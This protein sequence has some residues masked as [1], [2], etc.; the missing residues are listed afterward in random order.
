MN[1]YFLLQTC[2]YFKI[3][4][5]FNISTKLISVFGPSSFGRFLTVLMFGP[6]NRILSICLSNFNK[7]FLLKKTLPENN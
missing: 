7:T 1:Y 6:S 3:S 5:S 4:A 2:Y